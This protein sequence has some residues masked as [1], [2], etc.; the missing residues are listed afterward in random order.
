MSDWAIDPKETGS[1]NEG[2][3][4]LPLGLSNHTIT[5]VSRPVNKQDPSG[6]EQQVL[7]ETESGGLPY[8]IYL[9]PESSKE[10]VS[11]I[12]RKTLVAFWQAA[13]LTEAIKPDRLKKLVGKTVEI[14]AAETEGKGANAGKTFVN[15]KKVNPAS[16]QEEEEPQE[17]LEGEE[18][19]QQE[20]E[21]PAP[22]VK[23]SMPW[24]K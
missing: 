12:A 18:Q 23:K 1:I 10:S 19:E 6:K 4:R 24:K 16:E 20:E 22:K 14:E 8:K 7:I 17:D 11:N 5:G 21:A 3:N 9:N 2:G 13:G 15:I